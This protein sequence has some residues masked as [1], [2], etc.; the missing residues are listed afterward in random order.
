M[1]HRTKGR[2]STLKHFSR[3]ASILTNG[4]RRFV[5]AAKTEGATPI[6]ATF[7]PWIH[8]SIEGEPKKYSNN[9]SSFVWPAFSLIVSK[10]L[11]GQWLF[12][13][14]IAVLWDFIRTLSFYGKWLTC[15]WSLKR[16]LTRKFVKKS[17]FL[18]AQRVE[19]VL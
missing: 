6:R 4:I 5:F 15:C 16:Y 8:P 13:G 2:I 3:I 12:L 18:K 17:F 1:C 10:D 9:I 7:A 11:R 19:K 14:P